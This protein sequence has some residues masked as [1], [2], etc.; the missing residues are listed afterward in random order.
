L[1]KNFA[2]FCRIFIHIV[3]SKESLIK[4]NQ[5]LGI[6]S[7]FKKVCLKITSK[8]YKNSGIHICGGK[9]LRINSKKKELFILTLIDS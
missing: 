9:N 5:G 7:W 2:I 6:T 3:F 1:P 8:E 4:D